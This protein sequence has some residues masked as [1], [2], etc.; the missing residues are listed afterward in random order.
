MLSGGIQFFLWGEKWDVRASYWDTEKVKD[1]ADA[2][3]LLP[4]GKLCYISQ[5]H[6][7]WVTAPKYWAPGWEYKFQA[8]A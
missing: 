7:V 5:P 2:P 4:L 6:W 8:L 1:R 3:S